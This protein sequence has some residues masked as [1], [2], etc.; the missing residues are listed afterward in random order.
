MW[1]NKL[2]ES[3]LYPTCSLL[4]LLLSLGPEEAEGLRRCA[5]R[6]GSLASLLLCLQ[7]HGLTFFKAFS[8]DCVR[9]LAAACT[10]SRLYAGD[11]GEATIGQRSQRLLEGTSHCGSSSSWAEQHPCARFIGHDC[12]GTDLDPVLCKFHIDW[13]P[14]VQLRLSPPALLSC[15][16]VFE[17]GSVSSAFFVLLSGSCS[18]YVREQ[19]PTAAAEASRP[20]D[21]VPT[22]RGRSRHASLIGLPPPLSGSGP[23]VPILSVVDGQAR[24]GTRTTGGGEADLPDMQAI[25]QAGPSPS[26]PLTV[27]LLGAGERGPRRGGARFAT[28]NTELSSPR[29][30]S[31][32][33][34]R[35]RFATEASGVNVAPAPFPTEPLVPSL[36]TPRSDATACGPSNR[37]VLE[38]VLKVS[39]GPSS[40]RP[41]SPKAPLLPP[42]LDDLT[43]LPP[44]KPRRRPPLAT[45]FVPP[46]WPDELPPTRSPGAASSGRLSP[47]VKSPRGAPTSAPRP[48]SAGGKSSPRGGSRGL[49]DE[50][51][52]KLVSSFRGGAGAGPEP[53]QGKEADAR[54][55]KAGKRQGSHTGSEQSEAASRAAAVGGSGCA[56]PWKGFL[57]SGGDAD[58]DP[59]GDARKRWGR[60]VRTCQEGDAFGEKELVQP[61]MPLR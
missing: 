20:A 5:L 18:I 12:H 19:D 23:D 3:S 21:S 44:D 47:K 1:R 8:P 42:A 25:A 38:P 9:H 39:D 34:R 43:A 29:S 7:L 6:L 57:L 26:V 32:T 28:A 58:V 15:G 61:D 17:Q 53:S 37:P 49:S 30:P 13:E 48:P 46:P 41:A 10:Y 35:S 22:P 52:E 2:C 54:A 31:P 24:R 11:R 36:L 51:F 56:R 27:S 16:A 45:P 4:P 50:D 40:G 14:C 59:A 33:S 55:G 60:L